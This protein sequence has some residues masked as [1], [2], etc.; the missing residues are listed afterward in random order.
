M[1]GTPW[2]HRGRSRAG[3]D[4]AGLV[5]CVARRLGFA[6][7]GVLA[8]DRL[9]PLDLIDRLLPQFCRPV[10]EPQPGDVLHLRLAGR[11][12]HL[13]FAADYYGGGLSLIHATEKM[14]GGRVVEHGID[15]RWQRRI[16][17]AWRIAGVG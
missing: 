9:P 5:I 7:P 10:A 13:G 4:C 2:R 15:A 11:P 6:A 1:I 16:V 17:G 8:Y 14:A 12:Q 3:V